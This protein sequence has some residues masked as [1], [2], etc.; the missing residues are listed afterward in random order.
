MPAERRELEPNRS[1]KRL[2][3][4]PAIPLLAISLAAC[5]NDSDAKPSKEEVANGIQSVLKPVME[6]QV[7][8]ELAD[9]L[10]ESFY[11]CIVDEIYDDVSTDTLKALANGE[12][13]SLIS[14]D[15]QS[16]ITEASGS[17][18]TKALTN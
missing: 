11:S 2:I 12:A 4:L 15:D 10:D 1:I 3:A 9:L 18:A 5:G 7:G 6:E 16:E 8:S 14:A 13:N 17:C